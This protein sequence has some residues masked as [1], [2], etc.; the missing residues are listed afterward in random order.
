M[1]VLPESLPPI[2][3]TPEEQAALGYQED[4]IL[5]TPEVAFANL[6]QA[7]TSLRDRAIVAEIDY[8]EARAEVDLERN[9][10]SFTSYKVGNLVS[11]NGYLEQRLFD[12]ERQLKADGIAA[13]IL[14]NSAAF[15]EAFNALDLKKFTTVLAFVDLGHFKLFND[16]VSHGFGNQAI[17]VTGSCLGLYFRE[18]DT[19]AHAN[20][21]TTLNNSEV[22]RLHGDEFAIAL[23]APKGTDETALIEAVRSRAHDL[24]RDLPLYLPQASSIPHFHVD[25]GATIYDPKLSFEENMEIADEA[26]YRDKEDQCKSLGCPEELQN[27]R[28]PRVK[29]KTP[30]SQIATTMDQIA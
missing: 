3:Q 22:A 23:Q 27:R 25:I 11:R 17:R 28:T 5:F 19:I 13:G 1:S 6:V 26:M 20:W 12:V 14:P 9:K 7:N 29:L 21:S 15:E 2:G 18:T 8:R 4:W 16:L 24:G 10:N 30:D